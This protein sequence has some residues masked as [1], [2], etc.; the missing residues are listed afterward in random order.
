MADKPSCDNDDDFALFRAAVGPVK[1]LTQDKVAPTKAQKLQAKASIRRPDT[2]SERQVSASFAFSDHYQTVLPDSGPMRYCRADAAT[3]L[4]KQLRRGDYSPE[5]ILDLHGLT[6]EA[7][8]LE[9]AAL[10]HTAHKQMIECVAIVHGIGAGV[11]KQALPHLL[12]QHPHVLAFHQAPLEH[13][14][15]GALLVLVETAEPDWALR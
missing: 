10:L 9:L 15:Q 12:V 2:G 8:K 7:A 6:R 3:H 5:L 11:L 1:R 14:G 4:L 13:G